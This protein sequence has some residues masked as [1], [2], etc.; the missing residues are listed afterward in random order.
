MGGG[1][2]RSDEVILLRPNRPYN[3][4]LASPTGKPVSQAIIQYPVTN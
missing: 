1:M 2:S 3:N 4:N